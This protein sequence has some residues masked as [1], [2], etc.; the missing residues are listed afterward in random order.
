MLVVTKDVPVPYGVTARKGME[1][2]KWA[3]AEAAK[4]GHRPDVAAWISGCA[5]RPEHRDAVLVML[6]TA[7]DRMPAVEAILG[8]R[9]EGDRLFVEPSLPSS[10]DGF[11]TRLRLGNARLHITVKRGAK[12]DMTL[13]GKRTKT[14]IP[15]KDGDHEVVVTVV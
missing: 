5:T 11:E 14:Q 6:Q 7:F 15:V 8:I 1:R 12:A 10:W 3:A 4:T 13:N 2:L 9:R